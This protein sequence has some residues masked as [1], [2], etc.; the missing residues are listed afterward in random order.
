MGICIA[1]GFMGTG[2]CILDKESDMIINMCRHYMYICC[3]NQ[4]ICR[5]IYVAVGYMGTEAC[6]LDKESDMFITICRHHM[7]NCCQK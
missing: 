6:I 2:V 4:S 3:Q 5:C 1:A 7:H